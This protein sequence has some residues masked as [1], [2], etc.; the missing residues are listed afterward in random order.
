M[1]VAIGIALVFIVIIII[2]VLSTKKSDTSDTT[3]DTF[4]KQV[5]LTDFKNGGADACG[6]SDK[7][8]NAQSYNNLVFPAG[9][10]V[11]KG[12]LPNMYMPRMEVTCKK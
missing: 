7:L 8:V 11:C 10:V 2:I 5:C 12:D 4:K 9:S 1:I 3:S 6:G